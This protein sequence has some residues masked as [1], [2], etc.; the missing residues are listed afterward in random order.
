MK[1]RRRN[2]EILNVLLSDLG[3]ESYNGKS[4]GAFTTPSIYETL[5]LKGIFNHNI[6]KEEEVYIPNTI[7]FSEI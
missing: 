4:K 2:P 1:S 6:D 5:S 7:T 3:F